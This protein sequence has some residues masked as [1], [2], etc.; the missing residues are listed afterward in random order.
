MR[1][2]IGS[3][4][5]IPP[6][7]C[8]GVLSSGII[9]V[10]GI[11]GGAVHIDY[12]CVP[13]VIY[14][15]PVSSW[16]T[17]IPLT[18]RH[19]QHFWPLSLS[20]SLFFLALVVW[21]LCVGVPVFPVVVL[22]FSFFSSLLSFLSLLLSLPFLFPFPFSS[23]FRSRPHSRSRFRSVSGFRSP[24]GL[25]SCFRSRFPFRSLSRFQSCRRPRS[26][27]W[28]FV[29]PIAWSEWSFSML[30]EV[31]WVG[32][33]EEMLKE[34]VTNA[35]N[36]ATGANSVNTFSSA[37]YE[38]TRDPNTIDQTRQ[39]ITHACNST[40]LNPFTPKGDQYQISPATSPE[41]LHSAAWRTWL[42]IAYAG[43]IWLY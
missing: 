7:T 3:R 37:F 15:H 23:C 21:E 18:S 24:P 14:T 42:F 31:A 32:K 10:E 28:G 22:A 8:Y 40:V 35:W 27:I 12:N 36:L 19:L 2:A 26:R 41:I 43:E 39:N 38:F 17:A 1:N 11:T 34:E 16:L 30:Q 33:T 13:S 9:C 29:F 5:T 6:V 20:L 4:A 25:R